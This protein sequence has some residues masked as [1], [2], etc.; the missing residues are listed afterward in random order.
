MWTIALKRAYLCGNCEMIGEC[1]TTCPDCGSTAVTSLAKILD[2][3]S[4]EF[5]DGL[6]DQV[7]AAEKFA[8]GV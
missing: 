3:P 8:Q 2:R 4:S 7:Q 5:V 1:A 6:I